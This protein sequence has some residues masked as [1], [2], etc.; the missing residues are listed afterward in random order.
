MNAERIPFVSAI[1][2]TEGRNHPGTPVLSP[3]VHAAELC[4]GL[5][6]VAEGRL[7][8]LNAG[9]R[10]FLAVL[11]IRALEQLTGERAVLLP[12]SVADHPE[13]TPIQH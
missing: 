5:E 4:R 10:Q 13:S 1:G 11:L 3:P 12:K 8:D 7:D 6:H 2:E 9:A